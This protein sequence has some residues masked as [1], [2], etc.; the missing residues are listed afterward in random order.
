MPAA[1]VEFGRGFERLHPEWEM[2]LWTDADLEELGITD[3]E[4]R[5]ARSPSELSNLVRYEVLARHGG[6]YVD[7]DFEARRP[8]DDLLPGVELFAALELPGRA[9]CGVVGAVPGHRA[10]ERAA[11]LSRQTLGLG[12]HSADANGPYFLT[13]LLEQ[14]PEATIFGADKFYPYRWDEPERAGEPFPDAY[15]VHHWTLSWWAEQGVGVRVRVTPLR[16]PRHDR[17][18]CRRSMTAAAEHLTSRRL[19]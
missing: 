5:R 18:R 4:R 14:E 8:L 12:L 9:A 3:D 1:F 13:L 16:N 11:R 6:V 2:R 10:M 19:G 7:T 17:Y 15:A